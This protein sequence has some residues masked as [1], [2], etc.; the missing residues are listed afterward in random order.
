M[1]TLISISDIK[2]LVRRRM[3]P[4]IAIFS[5]VL[6]IAMVVAVALPPIYS[7]K[8]VI[9]IESQQ[10]SD[11][12]VK[13]TI[14]S[15]AEERLDMITREILKYKALRKLIQELDLYPDLTQKGEMSTA[16]DEMRQAIAVEPIS[17]KVGVKSVT[18]AFIL[19]YE[20]K[21]PQKTYAVA[22][23]L[24]KFYLE[25]EAETREK[26][27]AATTGFL[28]SELANL[29]QQIDEHENKISAFKQ[30][31]IDELPGSGAAN[32]NTLQRLRMELEQIKTRI[33]SLQDRKIYLDG[34][35]A[36]I[37]PLKPIQTETGK[38]ASNPQE[39]LK[40]LRLELIRAR[41]RL[42]DKHPD[43]KKLTSEI[44]NLEN[45]VGQPDITVAKVK[46]LNALR[47][48][49]KKLKA[50]KGEKHPDVINLSMQIK[51]LSQEVNV[52]L[53]RNSI[54]NLSK[55]KPDN[56]AYINLRTQIVSADLEI[57]NLNEDLAKNKELIAEYERRVENAP[58]V[59]RE[60]NALTIDYQNAKDR[61]NEV[62]GKLLQARVAQEMEVQ[63]HG[64]HFIIT[65]PP[66]VPSRPTKPNRL[67]IILLG[68]VLATGAGLGGAAFS[69]ATDHTIKGTKD[70]AQFEGIELLTAMPYTP[71]AE[72]IRYRWQKRLVLATG[73]IG[74]LSVVLVTVDRLIWPLSDI[75]STVI[76]RLT[77]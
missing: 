71:T 73:C 6:L 53:N 54:T 29:K 60:Y 51:D 5:L 3:K 13:S 64:E 41:S 46:Q 4:F 42:S 67:A 7:S 74:I 22:D 56:P 45:Q 19:S 55:E 10:I 34:Q 40:R 66:H 33:R 39:R 12:Y 69:E 16:V 38:V 68:L 59:E 8:A 62:S 36:N 31:H 32:L 52:L 30:Q 58:T 20:G 35:L 50:S 24:S 14:T 18:V 15:Y 9:I 77:F 27:A 37:E 28:E 48:E 26:Q 21:D 17:T 49:L 23:R 44:R 65:D 1:E 70:I 72:E 2:G 25:K 57:K 11:A 43:I 61:Y 76:E 63:Q 47:E 75:F